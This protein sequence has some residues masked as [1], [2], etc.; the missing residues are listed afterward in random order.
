MTLPKFRLDQKW[1]DQKSL[2][3]QK[4]TGAKVIDSKASG[5]KVMTKSHTKS[6]ILETKMAI[7]TNF[8]FSEIK[9]I[10]SIVY[11]WLYQNSD[12][13]LPQKCNLTLKRA[14]LP[15]FET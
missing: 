7:P 15:L 14:H 12:Q 8:N 2:A 11:L 13:C 10:Y 3:W 6:H 5:Q 9:L 4:A 1:L